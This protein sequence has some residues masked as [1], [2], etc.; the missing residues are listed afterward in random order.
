M[1]L[2]RQAGFP[3]KPHK[4]KQNSWPEYEGNVQS[5]IGMTKLRKIPWA[6]HVA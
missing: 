4:D 5:N 3:N 6:E 2:E 1:N